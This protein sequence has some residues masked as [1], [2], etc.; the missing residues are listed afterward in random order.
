RAD[1]P[2][3]AA[4]DV[5]QQNVLL[6]FVEAV[7]FVNK[8]DGWLAGI[9]QAVR[10]GGKHATHLGDIR[11][12]SAET[13]KLVPRRACDDLGKRSFSRPGW[14]V[15]NKRLYPIGLDGTTEN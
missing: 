4:F 5:G 8:K 14:P 2:Y 12:D 7:N 15:K 3:R 6:R 11:L 10:R 1:Q 9:R 13:L